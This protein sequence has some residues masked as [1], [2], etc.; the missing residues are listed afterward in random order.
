VSSDLTPEVASAVLSWGEG[1]RRD[2][3]WRRT[4]DPWAVLVSELMLQQT[5]VSRVLAKYHEFVEAYPTPAACASSPLADVIRRWSGLGYNR[6]A[7]SLHASACM[8]MQ[9]FAGRVPNSLSALRRLPG[10]G[11]YTARAVLAFAFETD[12]AVVDTNIARVLARMRG[13]SLTPKEVQVAADAALENGRALE[14]NQSLMDLGALLCTPR[15][16]CCA[17]C[18]LAPRCAWRGGQ[19]A[20]P[21]EGSAGVSGGQSRF[22]GSDRQGR[23]RLVRALRTAPVTPDDLGAVMGWPAD[24]DRANRVAATLVDDGLVRVVDRSYR[25]PG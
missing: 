11:P 16:P 6:R 3:P 24:P 15:L 8:I 21:A 7:V 9:E 23:G 19:E 12:A 25:L 17:R 20:D 14:W 2:L 22:E 1:A 13:R 4:R 5:Q 10:V 18:P